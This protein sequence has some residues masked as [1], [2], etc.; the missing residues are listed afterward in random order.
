MSAT[1]KNTQAV[2]LSISGIAISGGTAPADYVAGG[3][4]PVSPSTLGPGENCNITVTFTPSAPGLRTATLTLTDDAHTTPATVSLRGMGVAPVD[5][6]PGGS[7]IG[8]V[9]VGYTGATPSGTLT[10]NENGAPTSSGMAPTKDLARGRPGT[11]PSRASGGPSVVSP[12]GLGNANGLISITVTPANPSI[13]SGQTQQFTATGYFRNGT[14]Q[15]LTSSVLWTSS[16][17]GVATMN[18]AGLGTS[19]A[20]GSTTITATF[21]TA[22]P[23]RQATGVTPGTPIIN[24]PPPS[25][26]SGSTTLTA[27]AGFVLTGSLNTARDGHTA[28]LLNNGMVLITGGVYFNGSFLTLVGHFRSSLTYFFGVSAGYRA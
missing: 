6:T 21:V 14:T 25:P 23:L 11:L 17:P 16:A 10:N 1:L 20:A 22:V 4:C 18:A 15:N 12:S 3:N 24:N 2:P 26:I 28:T 9:A 5:T 13:A 7:N 8:A 19:I 27:T